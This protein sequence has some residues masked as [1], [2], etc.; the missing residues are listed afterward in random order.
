MELPVGFWGE[1]RSCFTRL[2]IKMLYVLGAVVMGLWRFS[3]SRREKSLNLLSPLSSLAFFLGSI[4]S[5]SFQNSSNNRIYTVASETLSWKILCKKTLISNDKTWKVPCASLTQLWV[6]ATLHHYLILKESLLIHGFYKI[7]V[8]AGF[9]CILHK[10][11]FGL[12]FASSVI[13]ITLWQSF[14]LLWV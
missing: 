12:S 7:Q 6:C 1:S 5:L 11:N 2:W 9:L 4:Y 8:I 10:A 14:F 13:F 3:S